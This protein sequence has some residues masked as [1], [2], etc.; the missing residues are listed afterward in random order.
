MDG[1]ALPASG[2][3]AGAED[4]CLLGL[5][6]CSGSGGLDLGLHL[7][8]PGHRT[9]VHVER[10]AYAVAIL[11]ARRTHFMNNIHGNESKMPSTSTGAAGETSAVHQERYAPSLASEITPAF[12]STDPDGSNCGGDP[13]ERIQDDAHYSGSCTSS[14]SHDPDSARSRGSTSC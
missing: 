8:L 1:V 13:N 4:A 11:V 5:S 7:A 6:L 14:P 3:P 9:V 2:L 12:K 10:D